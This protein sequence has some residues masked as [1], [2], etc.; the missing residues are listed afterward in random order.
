VFDRS[1]S[2]LC[3]AYNEEAIIGPFLERA[4]AL[5][6]ET[7]CDY[8]IVVVDDCSTDRTHAIIRE[9][10]QRC[11][12]I[13]LLRNPV[14]VNV[15]L[16]AQRAIAAATREFVFWQTVDWAYDISRLGAYL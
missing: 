9:V 13:V 7:V 5:L 2:L 8:E 1:V 10:Q 6:R 14:N 11:P 4:D 3:W 16:S 15:G 12:R